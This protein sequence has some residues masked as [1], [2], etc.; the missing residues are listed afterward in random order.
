[1]QISPGRGN[2]SGANHGTDGLKASQGGDPRKG[3]EQYN[4]EFAESFF[5]SNDQLNTCALDIGGTLIKVAYL[6]DHYVSGGGQQKGKTQF[7]SIKIRGSQ[8]LYVHFFNVNEL[9]HTLAFLIKN[10][11][12]RQKIFLTGGGAHKFFFYII[13]RI[14]KQ[15]VIIRRGVSEECPLWVSK[16]HHCE[17][18]RTLSVELHPRGSSL[19]GGHTH[20]GVPFTKAVLDSFPAC[21][22][23]RIYLVREKV[24]QE[25]E[26]SLPSKAPYQRVDKSTDG[27]DNSPEKELQG[28]L[29]LQCSR[30]DEMHCV[31]NGLYK[32]LS[33][34]KSVVRYDLLIKKE[35]PVQVKLPYEP[36][37]I[38]NIGS[39]ISILLS[40]GHN[41]YRRIGGT[42]IGGGTLLGLAQ[43]ILQKVSFEEL[44]RLAAP[45]GRHSSPGRL[46]S[47]GRHSP[48]GRH[49]SPLDLTL[50]HVRPDAACT[51][52]PPHAEHALAASFGHL[53][54]ILKMKSVEDEKSIGQAVARSLIT[55][56]SFNIGY[57]L[58]LLARIHGVRRLFFSGKYISNHEC[59]MESLTLG[60]YY[61][62]MYIHPNEGEANGRVGGKHASY[63][64]GRTGVKPSHQCPFRRWERNCGEAAR[65]D[66]LPEVLFLKHDGFLG[67]IG[68]FFS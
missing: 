47:P 41:K 45:P 3:R 68:C 32:L 66:A 7:L 43:M 51:G 42:A 23:V 39:G 54:N 61:H 56:V 34:K 57:L 11:L 12:M 31:M 60:V 35:V 6:S 62:Y 44:I 5:S 53:S 1:M 27:G 13:D 59:I 20:E 38:A 10:G 55:M 9:N 52:A 28:E 19:P 16:C 46:S 14:V 33:V 67:A 2:N 25:G 8:N 29:I 65:R 58:H 26:G 49:S 40:N 30:K 22:T 36:F 15:E 4:Y 37:I 18:T 50:R 48:P 17:T 21:E 63:W 64:G 24:K